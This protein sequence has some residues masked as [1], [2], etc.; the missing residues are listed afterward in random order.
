ML[1]DALASKILQYVELNEKLAIG[2]LTTSYWETDRYLNS[3]HL[4]WIN[5]IWIIQALSHYFLSEEK[6]AQ[7]VCKELLQ[8]RAGKTQVATAQMDVFSLLREMEQTREFY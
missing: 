2:K 8:V 3:P 6:D 5:K 4:F 7:S 1:Q